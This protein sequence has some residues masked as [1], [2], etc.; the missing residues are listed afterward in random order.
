MLCDGEIVAI[1]KDMCMT[2]PEDF[3]GVFGGPAPS[4]ASPLE[5]HRSIKTLQP[6]GVAGFH[7]K[8]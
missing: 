8:V 5:A 2:V 7:G 6:G 4:S 3:K 1:K